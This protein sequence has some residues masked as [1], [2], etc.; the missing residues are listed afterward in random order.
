MAGVDTRLC[1]A[2]SGR[3]AELPGVISS[4]CFE[5]KAWISWMEAFWS[6]SRKGHL[7]CGYEGSVGCI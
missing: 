2:A 7:E 5:R 1:L 3:R 4:L 6:A